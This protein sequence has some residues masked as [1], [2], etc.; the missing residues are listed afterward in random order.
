MSHQEMGARE[1]S[2]QDVEGG[3]ER[4]MEGKCCDGAGERW[5]EDAWGREDWSGMA[6]ELGQDGRKI[7]I[8]GGCL[9]RGHDDAE[10]KEKEWERDGESF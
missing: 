4:W 2:I 3:L 7:F 6:E 9:L 8:L 1:V 5:G 10:S